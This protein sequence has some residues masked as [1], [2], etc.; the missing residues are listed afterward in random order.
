VRT[1]GYQLVRLHFEV[2]PLY[3]LVPSVYST[4]YSSLPSFA[5]LSINFAP[6]ETS[7]S[8]FLIKIAVSENDVVISPVLFLAIIMTATTSEI[9]A[10]PNAVYKS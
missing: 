7:S 8:T 4:M 5:A 3:S 6:A 1:H 10:M 9:R 2:R